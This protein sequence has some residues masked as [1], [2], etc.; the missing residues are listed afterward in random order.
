MV[1]CLFIKADE[2][3][4]L[5]GVSQSEAYRIIKISVGE[6]FGLLAPLDMTKP[7]VK[8]GVDKKP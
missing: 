7:L 1:K 3:A 8:P 2:F 4:K 6:R 5:L